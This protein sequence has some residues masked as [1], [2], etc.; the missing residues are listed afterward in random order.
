MA[1]IGFHASHEQFAPGY[2]LDCV[3]R[4]ERAGFHAAMCSDHFHPWTARGGQAGFAWAWLG[5]ALQ[6]TALPFGVVSAPGQR[7]HP[8]IVAQ[9]ATTLAEMFPGRFWLAVGTGEALNEHI[10]GEPWP[11][12]DERNARL[13][14]CVE[15]I[16]ALWAGETVTHR[17]RIRVEAAKLYTRPQTPPLL[18]GAAVSEATAA[19]MGGWADGLITIS[20][21]HDQLARVVEA[22]RHGGGAGKPLYLQ[23]GMSFAPTEAEAVDSA[24]KGWRTAILPP[25]LN[26]EL[27]TPEQFDAVGDFVRPEDVAGKLRVSADVGR[28]I[29]WLRRDVELGFSGL[30][31][32]NV[33]GHL[34]YLIDVFGERVLPALARA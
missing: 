25:T 18:F 2:L 15:V 6:A 24:H 11:A 23:V 16:R 28:H 26:W 17:G 29:E 9:A 1:D 27:A 5:A 19:W 13:K 14:E 20:Q 3:Q 33:G 4:A 7:Y 31:M 30:Y 12:K 34:P 32:H 21:D 8:A 22:F 10:T